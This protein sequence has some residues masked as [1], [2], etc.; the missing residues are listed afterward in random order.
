MKERM[1]ILDFLKL[2]DGCGTDCVVYSTADPDGEEPLYEG[3]TFDM[4]WYVSLYELD[5]DLNKDI[6][7]TGRP[8]EFRH[9]LGAEHNNRPGFI[10]LVKE[11]V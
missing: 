6:Y 4:P 1:T 10:F 9:S 7:E 11:E 3:S 5:T 8:V 2:C